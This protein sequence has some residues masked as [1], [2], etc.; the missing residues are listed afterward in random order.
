[1][2]PVPLQ[3]PGVAAS[4]PP[5]TATPD[6]AGASVLTSGAGAG[7]G[8]AAGAGATGADPAAGSVCGPGSDPVPGGAGVGSANT[9]GESSRDTTTRTGD[10]SDSRLASAP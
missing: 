6:T 4:C 7:A 1:M 8:A 10:T 9:R 5:T 2:S 3:V